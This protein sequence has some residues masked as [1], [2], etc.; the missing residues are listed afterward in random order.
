VTTTVYTG[1]GCTG[2]AS[3]ETLPLGACEAF[4][5][6]SI[7][8]PTIPVTDATCTAPTPTP[9]PA[10]GFAAYAVSCSGGLGGSCSGGK[11]AK[12]PSLL[13]I[14]AYASMAGAQTCPSTYPIK[15]LSIS[16]GITDERTCT[17]CQCAA[18]DGTC[19]PNVAVYS[20]SS[21]SCDGTPLTTSESA[22]CLTWSVPA[23]QIDYSLTPSGGS[24]GAPTGG[25]PGGSA[26]QADPITVCCWSP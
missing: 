15:T 11:C 6:A 4:A 20:A 7:L 25:V 9:T 13:C 22:T 21:S 5:S 12:L 26:A 1:G 24:C 19:K 14:Y 23:G 10:S 2:T 8:L 18:S 17:P 3:T 16:S